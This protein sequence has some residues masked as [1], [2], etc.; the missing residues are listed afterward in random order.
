[1]DRGLTIWKAKAKDAGSDVAAAKMR[2]GRS[3]SR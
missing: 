1:M 3:S 2:S